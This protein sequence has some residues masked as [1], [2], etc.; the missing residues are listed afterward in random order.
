[1]REMREKVK[2]EKGKRNKSKKT[3]TESAKSA[4]SAKVLIP[5]KRGRPKGSKNKFKVKVSTERMEKKVVKKLGRPRKVVKDIVK[6]VAKKGKSKKYSQNHFEEVDM[7]NVKTFKF[8]GYCP[9]CNSLLC[10]N[11]LEMGKKTIFI[12]YRC[13]KRGRTNIL[14]TELSGESKPKSKK[15]FLAETTKIPTE[16]AASYQA[17]IPEEFEVFVAN[18]G[19]EDWQ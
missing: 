19:E 6:K 2:K 5:K 9:D 1:M 13:N 16:S 18:A 11:D 7:S 14:S 10:T 3:S 12:C 15:E 4:K 8:L 17:N